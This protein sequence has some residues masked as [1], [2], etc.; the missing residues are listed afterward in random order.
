MSGPGVKWGE[1]PV[2]PPVEK[3]PPACMTPI[4][5][6]TVAA[7]SAG[8]VWGIHPHFIHIFPILLLVS[9]FLIVFR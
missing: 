8:A 6:K 1:K 4:P 9:V 2:N 5:L 7:G 3:Y